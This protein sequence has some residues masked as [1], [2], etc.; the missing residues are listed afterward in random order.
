MKA[1]GEKISG[2]FSANKQVVITS[3]VIAGALTAVGIALAPFT[4]GA[5]LSLP[6]FALANG[7]VVDKPTTALIGEYK[8]AKSNPE[9]VTPENKMREVLEDNNSTLINGFAQ[10][11]RQII[12]AINDVD[13]EVSIG[14]D[15][16]AKSASRGNNNYKRMTGKPLIV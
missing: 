10:M 3:A 2:W 14:D 12:T 4:G 16:I 5:S 9:I 15:V 1:T 11:T 13:M 6:A 8:G 7:G